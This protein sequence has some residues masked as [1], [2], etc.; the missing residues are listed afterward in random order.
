MFALKLPA[1]A[2]RLSLHDVYHGKPL[3]LQ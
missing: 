1:D 3:L 2:H